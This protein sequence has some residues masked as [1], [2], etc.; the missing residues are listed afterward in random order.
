MTLTTTITKRDRTRR[1]KGG[2]VVVQ[3]RYVLNYREPRTGARKHPRLRM[4]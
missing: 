3:T 1:L 4:R 2:A